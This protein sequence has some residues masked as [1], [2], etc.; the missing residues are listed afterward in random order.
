MKKKGGGGG[1]GGERGG[2]GVGGSSILSCEAQKC[3]GAR[4]R[5]TAA[6]IFMG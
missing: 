1:G 2:R 4:T 5:M 3:R 6:C